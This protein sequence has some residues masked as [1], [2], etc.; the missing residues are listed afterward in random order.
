MIIAISGSVGTGKTT[1]AKQLAKKLSNYEVVHLNDWAIEFRTNE[2]LELQTFDFNLDGLINKVNQY[3]SNNL[4]K[5]IIFEGHFAHYIN[6]ELVDFLFI[7]SRDLDKLKHEYKIRGYN[8]AKI[9]DNL[10]VESFNLCFY[11]GLEERYIEE[12]QIFCIDNNSNIEASVLEIL[13]LIDTVSK[14]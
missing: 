2:V 10:E 14:K 9:D 3:I 13:G 7:I 5:N 12:K 4:N 11:E 1:I 8:K 6:P